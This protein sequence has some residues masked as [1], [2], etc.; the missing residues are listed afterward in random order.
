MKIRIIK[1]VKN[2]K[3]IIKDFTKKLSH[4]YVLNDINL[5]LVSGKIY[6]FVG[7]NGSGKTMLMRAICGLILPTT[8]HVEIDGKILGKDISFPNNVG[9]LIE[10]PG[11]ISSYSGF[12]NLKVLAQIK[13]K[14]SNDKIIEALKNVGLEPNDKKSFRKYSLGMKQKLGIAAAIMEEPELLILDEPFNGL[15]EESVDKVRNLILKRKNENNIIILSCHDSQE[16]EK[17]CDEIVEIKTGKI[18]NIC[19]NKSS[20]DKNE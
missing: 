7:K 3:I 6:G 11:F 17:M 14:I 2:L 4:N 20:E 12:K 13:N 16:I 9:A 10:N 19:E 18:V 1:D 8:G 5:E 15:D